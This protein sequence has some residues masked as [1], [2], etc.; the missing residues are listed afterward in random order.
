[1]KEK[2]AFLRQKLIEF[3]IQIA[4]LRQ[5][6]REQEDAFQSR[7]TGLFVGLFEV[8]DA[9][10]G[11]EETIRSREEGMDKTAR[12]LS[13]NIRSIQRKVVRLLKDHGVLQMAFPDNRA[14]MDTCKVVETKPSPDL[15]D[16]T[17]L[18]VVK[19]GYV[20]KDGGKVFRKA[21]VITVRNS[22]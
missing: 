8:L 18:T 17:I 5:A 12:A 3:Q 15:K 4:T 16:E 9:F 2:K 1:M 7:E 14:T 13:R 21:E 22:G 20:A 6:L 19:N 10:E 11:V